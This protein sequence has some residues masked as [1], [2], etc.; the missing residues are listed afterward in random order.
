MFNFVPRGE[1]NTLGS[2][3]VAGDSIYPQERPGLSL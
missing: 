3:S 1:M 2:C